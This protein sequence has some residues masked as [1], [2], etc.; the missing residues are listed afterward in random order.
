MNWKVA[1]NIGTSNLVF[2]DDEV[3]V[4]SGNLVLGVHKQNYSCPP[5]YVNANPWNCQNQFYSGLPYI[6]TAGGVD[7]KEIRNHGLVGD[8]LPNSSYLPKDMLVDYVKIYQLKKD[9]NTVLNVCNY[10][11]DTHD[12]KLKKSITIGNNVCTNSLSPNVHLRSTEGVSINGVFSV[13]LVA[14]LYITGD[15]CN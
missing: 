4:S 5:F 9:C 3:G 14:Q 8:G 11:F 2:I 1:D 12:N 13:P 15:V 6:Y 7:S 10:N